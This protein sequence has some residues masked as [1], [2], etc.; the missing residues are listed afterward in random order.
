MSSERHL[1][2][3]CGGPLRDGRFTV[4][5][6]PGREEERRTDRKNKACIR[7]CG[8]ILKMGGT[9]TNTCTHTCTQSNSSSTMQW[10]HKAQRKW[11]ERVWLLGVVDTVTFN[12]IATRRQTEHPAISG[13]SCDLRRHRIS[14]SN[15][16]DNIQTKCYNSLYCCLNLSRFFCFHFIWTFSFSGVSIVLVVESLSKAHSPQ[17]GS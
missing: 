14:H 16:N 9:Y 6:L 8:W 7:G 3:G 11:G 5:R 12:H 2:D 4:R 1:S 15:S 17:I 10:K 13:S